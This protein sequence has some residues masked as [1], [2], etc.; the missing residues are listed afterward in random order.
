MFFNRLA[1]ALSTGY[2]FLYFGELV[3]WAN[4]DPA[5]RLGDWVLTWLFYSFLGFV[6]LSMVGRFRARTVWALALAGAAFGWIAEGVYARTMF[7]TAE[8]PFPITIAWTGLAWH[9]LI[10][11]VFGWFILRRLLVGGQPARMGTVSFAF[12][13]LYGLWAIA[14]WVQEAPASIP[15]F[16]GYSFLTTMLLLLAYVI[17]Q[18]LQPF[19][20]DP[21][22][23]ETGAVVV[24]LLL[25]F[26]TV[27]LPSSPPTVWSLP[28]LLGLVFM[29]LRR[30]RA[31]ESR[32]SLVTAVTGRV[33][34]SN[35]A[36][37][38]ML[39]LA[40]TAVYAAAFWLN[41][42]LPLFVPFYVASIAAG[43]A[44]FVVSVVRVFLTPLPPRSPLQGSP[45]RGACLS[46]V[47]RHMPREDEGLSGW[48]QGDGVGQSP[49]G[50]L[51]GSFPPAKHPARS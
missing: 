3:F 24:F 21:S 9:A 13:L 5:S 10:D 43:T 42:R 26:I 2:I 35:A 48:G 19:L 33:R 27:T 44:M 6:F 29:A 22:R 46:E 25:S 7:G 47:P 38:F 37:L 17:Y 8:S 15:A 51:R 34:P 1:L 32:A 31:V 49:K 23:I 11:V 16:A 39:P 18:R 28:L 50:T 4:P 45:A 14:W 30:N 40:A 36:L 41:L 20:F 12:G